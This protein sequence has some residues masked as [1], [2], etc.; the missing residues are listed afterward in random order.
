M[1]K[2]LLKNPY[3]LLFGVLSI[4]TAG[5]VYTA[6]IYQKGVNNERAACNSAKTETINDNIN[7]K[8][9]QDNIM[10]PDTPAYIKRLRDG[11]A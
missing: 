11:K 3:I 2:F 6:W 8:K 5:G 9:Q 7:I 1:I 10:R 4:I